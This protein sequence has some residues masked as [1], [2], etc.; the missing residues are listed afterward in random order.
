MSVSIDATDVKDAADQEVNE[1]EVNREVNEQEAGEQERP[2]EAVVSSDAADDPPDPPASTPPTDDPPANRAFNHLTKIKKAE[3]IVGQREVD[4]LAAKEEVKACRKAYDAAVD[5]LRK[6]I[7]RGEERL[8]LIDGMDDGNEQDG[9]GQ[10]GAAESAGGN[11]PA[12]EPPA[13]WRETNV[14]FLDLS[15]GIKKILHEGNMHTIGDIADFGKHSP[16]TAIPKVGQA[17]AD[18]IE[19]ALD[20]FWAARGEVGPEGEGERD[21]DLHPGGIADDA[22]GAEG[23]TEGDEDDEF[24][25][26]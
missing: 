14:D 21:G 4:L 10:A 13:D 2:D 8:P 15:D 11:S 19:A 26:L 9:D 5:D 22:A 20:E 18:R 23:E 16:L 12:D 7:R 25:D 1:Q 3:T 17:K 24:E 6:A